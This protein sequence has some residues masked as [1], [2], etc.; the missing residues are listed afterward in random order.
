MLG[1]F[2]VPLLI[3]INRRAEE[4]QLA[5]DAAVLDLGRLPLPAI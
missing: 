1:L 2:A 3:W 5:V 4:G